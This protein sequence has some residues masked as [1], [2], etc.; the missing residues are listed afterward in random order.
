MN[1]DDSLGYTTIW[2]HTLATQL[3]LDIDSTYYIVW[4]LKYG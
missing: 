1:N 4:W 3:L 2:N